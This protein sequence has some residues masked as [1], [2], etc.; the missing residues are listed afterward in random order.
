MYLAGY[1]QLTPDQLIMIVW[2]VF[3][4]VISVNATLII[5][6]IFLYLA[7]RNIKLHIEKKI[8]E[9]IQN[10]LNKPSLISTIINRVKG[11]MGYLW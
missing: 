8:V 4:M 9:Q 1:E 7:S 3:I 10:D 2:L 5:R 6:S 11:W